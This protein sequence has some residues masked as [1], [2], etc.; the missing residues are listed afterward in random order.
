VAAYNPR[1][2]PRN[3][4]RV[5]VNYR[6][7]DTLKTAGPLANSLCRLLDGAPVFFDGLS[8]QGGA[9][10]PQTLRDEIERSTV[11]L[12]LIGN[13]WLTVNGKHGR[14]RLDEDGDWVRLEIAQALGS[15]KTVIPV[16]VDGAPAP[17][18]DALDEIQGIEALANAQA[19]SFS[20][21]TFAESVDKL[22]DLLVKYDFRR[23][24]VRPVGRPQAGPIRSTIPARGAAPFVGR[25]DLIAE[26]ARLLDSD[27]PFVVLHGQPGVGKSELA[28]EFARR[29]PSRFPGGRF[30]V[31][32]RASGPPVDL[33]RLGSTIL[34]LEYPP[35]M[36]LEVQAYKALY[37]LAPQSL[38]IYDNAESPDQVNAWLPPDGVLANVLVTTTHH[39][40]DARWQTLLVEPLTERAALDIVTR[41]AGSI[42]RG[43]ASELVR[44]SRGIPARLV[45]AAQG[46]RKAL[47]RGHSLDLSGEDGVQSSFAHPWSQA[48]PEARVLLFTCTFFHPGR[49]SRAVLESTLADTLGWRQRRT[50]FAIGVAK[51]Q[52]LL[53]GDEPL[54]M[55]QLLS[56]FIRARTDDFDPQT[57]TAI[58]SYLAG[59]LVQTSRVVSANPASGEDTLELLSFS[60]GVEVW[61]AAHLDAEQLHAV[62]SALATIGRFEEALPWLERAAPLALAGGGR[63]C[64]LAAKSLRE[65]GNC[66]LGLDRPEEAQRQYQ[67]ALDT[68][69]T[70]EPL[71]P[72]DHTDRARNMLQVGY[73]LSKREMY[74]EARTWYEQAA[75]TALLAGPGR[76]DNETISASLHQ[77]GFCLIKLNR[78]DESLTWFERARDAA[79]RGDEHE[80]VDHESLGRTLGQIGYYLS[81]AG[82]HD[83][84]LA[85]VQQAIDAKQRGDVHGRVDRASVGRSQHQMGFLL[86]QRNRHDEALAWYQ[87][88]VTM[89][90]QGDVY[91]RLDHE[92]IGRS[93]HQVAVTLAALTR[94]DDARATFAR[95]LAEKQ[96]GNTFGKL[97]EQ[98]IALTRERLAAL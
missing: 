12:V 20:S 38:L 8:L 91:G 21:L 30:V 47:A 45:P 60:L 90:Q 82:K 93:L 88:A 61:E 98:S 19:T 86:S 44:Q 5:F 87:R 56:R 4:P 50:E 31:D 92:A 32:M 95:A 18:P 62:G 96:Q 29:H 73:C 57:L 75:D 89:S 85:A 43:A 9:P 80:H 65:T 13:V 10:W 83:E 63:M 84:A 97:D 15:G 2:A 77:V 68:I 7:E 72:A 40:W 39:D 76:I 41:L 22:C 78:K 3:T 79:L 33:S 28:R 64:A 71:E 69:A 11:V 54:R 14:R 81:L 16:L 70:C 66:L 55:H 27:S 35:L 42:D 24:D 6:R 58:E 94:T 34:E 1:V 74:E 37:S 26:I 49:I 23:S 51:D 52:S 36:P 46:A 53:E 48:D 67:R 25:D 17:P 59:R